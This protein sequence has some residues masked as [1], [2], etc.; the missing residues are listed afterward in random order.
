M[1]PFCDAT[2]GDERGQEP[3]GGARAQG[4]A[5]LALPAAAFARLC[6]G[7]RVLCI[8]RDE[9]RLLGHVGAL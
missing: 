5:G 6:V 3:S 1:G 9:D 7:P 8:P 2:F 4:G